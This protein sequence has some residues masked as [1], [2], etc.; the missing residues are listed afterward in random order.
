MRVLQFTR[1]RDCE[2][3]DHPTRSR[4]RSEYPESG[5]REDVIQIGKLHAVSKIDMIG[6]EAPDR[7]RVRDA[8]EGLLDVDTNAFVP[9]VDEQFFEQLQD[10]FLLDERH[11]QIELRVLE[12]PV[13]SKVLV[14]EA[15]SDLV[16]ALH[17]A[18][19]EDLLQNLRSLRQAAEPPTLQP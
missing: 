2:P 7:L 4:H 14:T 19:H 13:G 9:Q 5:V 6:P 18:D 11:L 17:P 1:S 10:V 16:V 15:A 3:A 8:W 12:L